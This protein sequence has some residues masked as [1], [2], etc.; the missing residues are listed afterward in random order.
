MLG[1]WYLLTL[2]IYLRAIGRWG[3]VLEAIGAFISVDNAACFHGRAS[4][5]PQV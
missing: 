2:S 5:A 4:N 1:K 3:A